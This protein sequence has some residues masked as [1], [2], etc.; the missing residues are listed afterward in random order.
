MATRSKDGNKESG[1][2]S[3]CMACQVLQCKVQLVYNSKG[4]CWITGKTLCRLLLTGCLQLQNFFFSSLLGIDYT[5]RLLLPHHLLGGN[6][7]C[8][9]DR[10][11]ICPRSNHTRLS[12]VGS[13][14]RLTQKA[15]NII[16]MK[17]W[18]HCSLGSQIYSLRLQE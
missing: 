5:N 4:L 10:G 6:M 11:F 14:E 9:R 7:D 2:Q 13:G 15:M 16:Y 1:D 12:L 18:K 8:T 17:G 3:F